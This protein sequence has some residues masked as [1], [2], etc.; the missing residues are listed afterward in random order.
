MAKVTHPLYERFRGRIKGIVFRLSHNGKT[1]AYASP[2]M[3]GV[4]WSPAQIAHREKL[5][6]ASAYAKAATA[7]P[8]LRALYVE[9]SME[10][11]GNK[12]PYDMAVGDYMNGINLLGDRFKWDVEHWRSMKRYRKPK[13]R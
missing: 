1:T 3:S 2:D 8:Q 12:R 13:K 5:A 4:K 11:K 6:A 7:D 10:K 9:M